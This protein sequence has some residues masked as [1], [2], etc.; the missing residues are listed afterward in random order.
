[1]DFKDL[2]E[3]VLAHNNKFKKLVYI[4]DGCIILNTTGEYCIEL[5]RC[6]TPEKLLGWVQHL[7]EKTW[8]TTDILARFIEVASKENGIK[9]E[10]L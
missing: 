9:L 6:N 2:R 4:E 8:M 5:D 1:M 10:H 7:C 3:R